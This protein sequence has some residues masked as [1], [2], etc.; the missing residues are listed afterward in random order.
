MFPFI[1]I[2]TLYP[3]FMFYHLVDSIEELICNNIRF[4]NVIKFPLLLLC[5][6]YK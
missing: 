1:F 4:G 3:L 2:F 5:F 6:L